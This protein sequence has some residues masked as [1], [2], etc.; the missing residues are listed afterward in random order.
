MDIGAFCHVW[1]DIVEDSKVLMGVSMHLSY[2]VSDRTPIILACLLCIIN[3]MDPP[4]AGS[5]V[6][7]AI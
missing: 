5:K 1:P 3:L 4:V 2:G 6:L 7:F